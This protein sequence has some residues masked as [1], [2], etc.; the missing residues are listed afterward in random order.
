VK[1]AGIGHSADYTAV[2]WTARQLQ[3]IGIPPALVAPAV[4]ATVRSVPAILDL[5]RRG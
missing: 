1:A 5:C 2:T 3:D 4:L